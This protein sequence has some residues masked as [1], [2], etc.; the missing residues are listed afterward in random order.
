MTEV[1]HPTAESIFHIW[2][3]FHMDGDLVKGPTFWHHFLKV[4]CH[5][6]PPEVTYQFVHSYGNRHWQFS[7]LIFLLAIF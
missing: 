6:L 2:D 4:F 1:D 3:L 7:G 5:V